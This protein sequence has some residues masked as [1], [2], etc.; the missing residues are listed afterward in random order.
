MSKRYFIN[1]IDTAVGGALFSELTKVPEGEE[2]PE[3]IHMGTHTDP[4]CVIKPKGLKKLLKRYK[5]KLSRKKMLEECDVYVYDL[6]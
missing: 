6:H 5:P 1:N 3:P 2:P 4:N